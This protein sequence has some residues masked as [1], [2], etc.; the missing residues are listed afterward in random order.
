VQEK[1]LCVELNGGAEALRAPRRLLFN[2][3]ATM[4][5]AINRVGRVWTRDDDQLVVARLI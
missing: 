1:A 2:H 5:L 3:F 4:L